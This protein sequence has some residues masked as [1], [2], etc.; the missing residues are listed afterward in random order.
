MKA[1]N[2]CVK[3]GLDIFFDATPLVNMVPRSILNS[4]L[5]ATSIL[6]INIDE[7]RMLTGKLSINESLSELKS[8]VKGIIVVKLGDRGA[9]A[10]HDD[11]ISR[12]DGVKVIPI[13]TTGA[14]DAFNAAFIY[15]YM[16]GLSIEHSLYLAN[17]VGALTVERFGAGVNLPM[18][19]DI[20]A[21][22]KLRNLRCD[23]KIWRLISE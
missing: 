4:I 12:V 1:F 6:F 15:G 19:R 22:I 14:G 8:T 10:Y 13:D 9:L 11:I 2:I 20:E 7:L 5:K 18:K 3:R 17:I 21:F 23:D 16:R